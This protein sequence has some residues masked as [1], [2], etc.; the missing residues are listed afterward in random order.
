[1]FPFVARWA[2]VATPCGQFL[3][4]PE[5]R[6][7]KF[8]RRRIQAGCGHP[9]PSA[10]S[11]PTCCRGLRAAEHQWG[12]GGRFCCHGL[13]PIGRCGSAPGDAGIFPSNSSHSSCT[14]MSFADTQ[15]KTNEGQMGRGEE[16]VGKS[17]RAED[18]VTMKTTS[19]TLIWFFVPRA[20]NCRCTTH[21]IQPRFHRR[22]AF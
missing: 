13:V 2:A 11:L 1:M 12:H 7:Q 8:H 19:F 22:Y 10:R 18:S 21:E 3:G 6:A 16:K 5:H 9:I 15:V 14:T 17:H 4:V 20:R